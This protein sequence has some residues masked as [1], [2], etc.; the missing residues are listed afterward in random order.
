MNLQKLSQA[1]TNAINQGHR[2]GDYRPNVIL[3]MASSKRKSDRRRLIP[4]GHCP[5]GKVIEWRVD[6]DVV[7]FDAVDLLAWCIARSNGVE[8]QIWKEDDGKEAQ[9][10]NS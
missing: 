7:A 6:G 8:T 4:E 3:K 5:I 10:D 2:V 9:N 1:C